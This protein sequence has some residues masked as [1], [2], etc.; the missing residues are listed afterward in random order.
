MIKGIIG[1]LILLASNPIIASAQFSN[2]HRWTDSKGQT[3]IYL[4]DRPA[5]QPVTNVRTQQITRR[6]IKLNACGIGRVS[7]TE[8]NEIFGFR[9]ESGGLIDQF[10]PETGQQPVPT[11]RLNEATGAYESNW[12]PP[13]NT[14]MKISFD[15]P[16]W[17]LKLGAGAGAVNMDIVS[18]RTVSSNTN[19]CG[20]AR[21]R[22]LNGVSQLQMNE[23]SGFQNISVS[24]LPS[25]SAPMICR[26]GVEYQPRT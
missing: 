21:V 11:C 7:S 26:K 5:G 15:S 9:T 8:R 23:G 3:F 20:F 12:N 6:I 10:A 16:D 17:Y 2:I 4:P 22:L 18:W 25:V 24:G 1:A 13:I 19:E 14:A